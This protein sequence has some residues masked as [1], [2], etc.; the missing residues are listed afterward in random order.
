MFEAYDTTQNVVDAGGGTHQVEELQKYFGPRCI[1]NYYLTRP[2]RTLLLTR[3]ERKKYRKFNMFQIDKTYHLDSIVDLIK[4]H[5]PHSPR[6]IL[7]SKNF[8]EI[9]WIIHQFVNEEVEF[10]RFGGN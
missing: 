3:A 5:A 7:P 6:L 1:K 10:V 2:G 8:R 9:E 4:V